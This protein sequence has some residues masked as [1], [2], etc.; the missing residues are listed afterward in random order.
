MKQEEWMIDSESWNV[1][2]TPS[3]SVSPSDRQ[4]LEAKTGNGLATDLMGNLPGLLPPKAGWSE[5]RLPY[6][7]RWV[8]WTPSTPVR[9]QKIF[10][11]H[12]QCLNCA[13]TDTHIHTRY[14]SLSYFQTPVPTIRERLATKIREAL[15]S[16]SVV[17]LEGRTWDSP[18]GS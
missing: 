8:M 6:H 10:K 17:I 14:M 7:L 12:L 18:A 5:F 9:R 4:R 16:H 2:L 11:C 3:R 15:C 13:H 1:P